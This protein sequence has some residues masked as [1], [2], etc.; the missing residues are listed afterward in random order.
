MGPRGLLAAERGLPRLL[1][2]GN[3][4]VARAGLHHPAD[5]RFAELARVVP[6]KPGEQPAPESEGEGESESGDES[7]VGTPK[8]PEPRAL[9]KRSDGQSRR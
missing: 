3:D 6:R 5:D 1:P 8:V 9:V 4:D 2:D 7:H